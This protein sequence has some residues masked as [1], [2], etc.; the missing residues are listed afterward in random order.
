MLCDSVM[1]SEFGNRNSYY[2]RPSPDKSIMR[3]KGAGEGMDEDA[4]LRETSLSKAR[5][6]TQSDV[7]GDR[8]S[9]FTQLR[10]WLV[11][12]VAEGTPFILRLQRLRSQ[13]LAHLW[14]R[15]SSALGDQWSYM[16]ILPLCFW[17]GDAA[18][19]ADFTL[20]LLLGT[21]LGN[22]A[23]NVFALPRPPSPPVVL[24]QH[25]MNDFGFPSVHTLNAVTVSTVLVRY[26]W[27]QAYYYATS[28]STV[29][30]LLFAL[31][32]LIA[33]FWMFS[34]PLSRMYVG[35]HSPLDCVAGFGAGV[36]FSVLWIAVYSSMIHW[37]IVD[38]TA[39][40]PVILVAAFLAIVVHPRA[41]KRSP[42]YRNNIAVIG[43]VAG[44]FIGLSHYETTLAAVTSSNY[45]WWPVLPAEALARSLGVSKFIVVSVGR[46]VE[47]FAIVGL[48]KAAMEPLLSS[49]FT[50]IF[51]LPVFSTVRL[52]LVRVLSFLTLPHPDALNNVDHP[53]EG[54]EADIADYEA[55][56]Q[57][58]VL[59]S[60]RLARREAAVLARAVTHLA[61]GVAVVNWL[62]V[63][64]MVTGLTY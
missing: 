4:S 52:W 21:I 26:H 14:L 6:R 38:Q 11:N 62:R 56:L 33:L 30:M 50:L 36:I 27:F 34:I 64:F 60:R 16:V 40:V 19:G 54:F 31:S 10:G 63:L 44:A 61:I 49:L 5:A 45:P 57:L 47:G 41:Q 42:S 29:A 7:L 18:L 48:I 24:L 32:V 37:V 58:E 1:C 15:G 53:L 55:E 35:V 20:C 13:P 17:T 23:K 22:F 28:D 39:L 51:I 8:T 3:R 2:T 59:N 43:I 9:R 46:F 12:V 25:T